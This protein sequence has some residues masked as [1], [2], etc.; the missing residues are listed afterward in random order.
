MSELL[1]GLKIA[2]DDGH[3]G[4]DPGAVDPIQPAE[5][6]NIDTKEKV[7]NTFL[8]D[9]MISLLKFHGAEVLD[10]RP[11]DATVSLQQ[12]TDRANNWGADLYFSWHSNSATNTSARG[13]EA[14]VYSKTSP[15]FKL[16]QL[17][18]ERFKVNGI[19]WRRVW[20]NNFHV[21]RETRMPAIL[22]ESGF[23]TNPAEERL[24]NT[25]EYLE[26]MAKAGF[27]AVCL[28]HAGKLPEE[29]LL[30]KAVKIIK[31]SGIKIDEGYW[32]EMA[33]PG[34]VVNGEYAGILLKRIADKLSKG[35]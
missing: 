31:E 33:R 12:R 27:E 35:V 32:T 15:A 7:I 21:L 26:R 17:V 16:A 34:K 8:A 20:V 2:V 14:H 19:V 29:D 28:W 5:G 10:V 24:L 9:Y 6:D 25:Q 30:V 4:V 13:A 11:G 3:G 1:K 23:I 22:V 18:E